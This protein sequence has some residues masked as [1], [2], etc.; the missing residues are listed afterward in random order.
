MHLC[1]NKCSTFDYNWKYRA[2]VGVCGNTGEVGREDES[3]VLAVIC[4]DRNLDISHFV[5]KVSEG[6]KRNTQM[7]WSNN[8]A[9]I[10]SN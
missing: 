2:S 5:G 1:I 3:S 7:Q 6:L 10:H 8:Y 9:A 4:L